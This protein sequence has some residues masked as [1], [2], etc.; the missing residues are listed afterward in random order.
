MLCSWQNAGPFY[1]CIVESDEEGRDID[2]GMRLGQ[3]QGDISTAVIM[4]HLINI[5]LAMY[6]FS[7]VD[8]L[9]S[10]PA[11]PFLELP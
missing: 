6:E 4:V 3:I 2:T 10:A 9:G 8:L 7:L 11:H 5:W 1:D